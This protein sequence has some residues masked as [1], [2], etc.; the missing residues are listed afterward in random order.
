V[1]VAN[2][3]DAIAR[4]SLPADRPHI[5]VRIPDAKDYERS[6]IPNYRVR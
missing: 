4:Q 5:D 3:A 2:R 1:L 6:A